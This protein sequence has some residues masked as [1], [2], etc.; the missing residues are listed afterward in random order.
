LR[1]AAPMA[2]H[3]A[4]NAAHDSKTAAVLPPPPLPQR[5]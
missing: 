5:S 3:R 4:M 2:A 1:V